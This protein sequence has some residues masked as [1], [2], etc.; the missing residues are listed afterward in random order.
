MLSSPTATKI[1]FETLIASNERVHLYS[2]WRLDRFLVK[3]DH[4]E[5]GDTDGP[6]GSG[7][8]GGVQL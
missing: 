2:A 6:A 1:H 5:E 7:C 4:A 8:G 3:A